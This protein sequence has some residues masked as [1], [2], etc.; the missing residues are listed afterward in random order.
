MYCSSVLSSSSAAFFAALWIAVSIRTI[1][2]AM[3]IDHTMQKV[4]LQLLLHFTHGVC[5]LAW[6][7]RHGT[8]ASRILRHWR[9][10]QAYRSIAEA[11]AMVG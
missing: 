6:Y 2:F 4:C 1:F 5:I 11:T 3:Q 9:R 10:L 7:E 8:I